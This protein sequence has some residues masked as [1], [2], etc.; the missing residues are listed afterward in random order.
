MRF[1]THIY[2]NPSTVFG[3][4]MEKVTIQ[5]TNAQNVLDKAIYKMH[6]LVVYENDLGLGIITIPN[7][8]D[9]VKL[10]SIV[11]GRYDFIPVHSYCC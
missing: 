11:F 5:Y 6:P 3:I 1:H 7:T 9:A 2:S 10:N 4:F 8:I